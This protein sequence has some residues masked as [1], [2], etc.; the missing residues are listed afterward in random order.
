MALLEMIIPGDPVPKGRPRAGRNGA[1]YTPG[2]TKAAEEAIRALVEAEL[3]GREPHE[4]PVGIAARFY[5]KGLT[6]KDGD[7]LIKLLTDAIQRGR[8]DVGG[9]IYDDAQIEEW[10][11]RVYRG[12]PGEE[13]RT[14]V[15]VYELTDSTTGPLNIAQVR[16]S[17]NAG[18]RSTG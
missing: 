3:R 2:P 16:K 10:W 1:V 18:T 14:E 13:P 9:V 6:R 5:C 15:L 7:N 4:G 12:A 8:R 17:R 11:F